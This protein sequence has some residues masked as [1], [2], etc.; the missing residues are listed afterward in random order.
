MGGKDGDRDP[1]RMSRSRVFLLLN[2]MFVL[3]RQIQLEHLNKWSPKHS[4]QSCWDPSRVE[5]V[6]WAQ[7]VGW[8]WRPQWKFYTTRPPQGGQVEK[9]GLL[10]GG[11][12]WRHNLSRT[13]HI[14]HVSVVAWTHR[15]PACT[16][17]HS[18]GFSLTLKL[19][20]FEKEGVSSPYWRPHPHALPR[21]DN[22]SDGHSTPLCTHF[23][24]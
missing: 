13:A 21:H 19:C 14:S 12:S 24:Q 18:T 2:E 17:A 8:A 20:N 11:R 3:R 1:F 10:E 6:W 16:H 4:E 23:S 7:D 15:T 5:S 9:Y 22:P